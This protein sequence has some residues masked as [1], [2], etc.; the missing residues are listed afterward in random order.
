MEKLI[1]AIG[2]DEYVDVVNQIEK[3]NIQIIKENRVITEKE[4]KK[5]ITSLIRLLEFKNVKVEVQQEDTNIY[6]AK[7]KNNEY[8]CSVTEDLP[9]DFLITSIDKN[10][11]IESRYLIDKSFKHHLSIDLD[12][13]WYVDRIN[14]WLNEAIREG[15]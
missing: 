15:V 2:F 4:A 5:E 8:E 13:K 14:D 9:T 11:K 1:S 6:W 12:E 7:T 3:L 10:R